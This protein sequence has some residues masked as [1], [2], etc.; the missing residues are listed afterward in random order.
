MIEGG[1]SG[2]SS[3]GNS[4]PVTVTTQMDNKRQGNDKLLTVL[5]AKELPAENTTKPVEG[6][7]YF[8]LDGKHKLKDMIVMYRGAAGKLDLE[9]VH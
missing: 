3:P 6:L 4:A 5:K 1:G 8:P 7:L 9:F 2:I